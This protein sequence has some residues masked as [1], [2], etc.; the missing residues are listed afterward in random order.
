MTLS[1]AR[2]SGI[3]VRARSAQVGPHSSTLSEKVIASVPIPVGHLP[4]KLG[5]MEFQ[6]ALYK[7]LP[8]RTAITFSPIERGFFPGQ[9][10]KKY[11]KEDVF[12]TI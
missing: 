7:R 1:R 6:L 8:G 4:G 9:F 10:E 2:A 12:E 11:D 5:L 3:D